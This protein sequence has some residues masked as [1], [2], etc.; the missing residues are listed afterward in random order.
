VSSFSPPFMTS[1]FSSVANLATR[2]KRLLLVAWCSLLTLLAYGPALTLPFFFDDFVHLPFVD[3][4]TFGAIWQTAGDLAY[5]RPLNFALWKGLHE[6]V[7]RHDPFLYHALNLLLHLVNGLLVGALAACLWPEEQSPYG[8]PRAYLASTLFLLYPMS[9]QAVPWVGS[10]SHLLVTFFILA[11]VAAYWQLRQTGNFWYGALS[12][13]AG[14]LALFT[15]ENGVLL[16]PLLLLVEVSDPGVTLTRWRQWARPL[17]WLLP[18]IAWFPI[19]RFAP[20][21]AGDLSLNG[22]EALLQNSAYFGQGIAYPL[23]WIGGRLARSTEVNDL[24]LALLLSGIALA[25]AAAVQWSGGAGRRSLLPWLWCGVAVTP[26]ILFLSFDYVINGPRLLMLAAVGAAWLWADVVLRALRGGR[27]RIVSAVVVALTLVVVVQNL[28]FIWERLELHRLLGTAVVQAVAVTGAA[29]EAGNEAVIINFPSWAAPSQATFAIGHEGALFWPDYVPPANLVTVH[30]ARPARLSFVR[31]E[32]IRPHL[33]YLYQPAG[34]APDWPALAGGRRHF[35]VADYG[36]SAVSLRPAGRFGVTVA[37]DEP[38]ATF[39]GESGEAAVYLMAAEA[40]R[41][42]S[43]L[44]L[45]LTWQVAQ[46]LPDVT[47]FVH[48][49]EEGRLAHQA[50]GDPL[51]GSYPFS[52][53]TV[54]LPV[55]DVRWLETTAGPEAIL[56]GLYNRLGGERLVAVRADGDRWPDGAVSLELLLTDVPAPE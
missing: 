23:T 50:D 30:S 21:A 10:L 51:A 24:L 47:V 12:L 28:L 39:F 44:E 56:V 6:L 15:H 42:E 7:G 26:A 22:A 52:Q 27:R 48:L 37:A 14:L 36:T 49:L 45:R 11:G 3:G 9:Y 29:N 8:S 43:G 13:L 1:F 54:A 33:P 31:V 5:Y 17:L 41:V 40:T 18:V 55:E 38:L 4:H 35:F 20:K 32:A 46:P 25:V 16:A 34:S 19:W 2:Q 53:W